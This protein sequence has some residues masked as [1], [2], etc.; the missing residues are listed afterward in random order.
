MQDGDFAGLGAFQ[1]QYGYVGVEIVAGSARVI[2][3]RAQPEPFEPANMCYETGKPE[4]TAE[5]IPFVQRTV[6]L[7]IDFDFR[8]MADTA[9][10]YYSLDGNRLEQDWVQAETVIQ[11]DSFC[12]LPL[13]AV[14]LCYEKD[15]RIRIF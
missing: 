8:D 5:S 7:R 2:M 4:V 14:Q 1:D 9:D 12:G 13:C 10:F 3:N 15:R 11:A 6:H